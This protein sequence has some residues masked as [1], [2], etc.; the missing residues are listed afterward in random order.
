MAG[1]PSPA[2]RDQPSLRLGYDAGVFELR[3]DPITGWWSAIVTDRS[4]EHS[5]FAVE[6]L[7]V[8][9][10]HCRH[11]DEAPTEDDDRVRRVTL[12]T[13]AF[14]RI[15]P[16]KDQGAQMAISEVQASSGSW[17]ILVGPRGHH[18]SLA[19]ARPQLAV[20]LLRG[21]RD[22][23]REIGEQPLAEGEQRYVQ[24]VQSYGRA[25]LR[26]ALHT[27]RALGDHPTTYSCTPRPPASASTRPSTGTGS[28]TL[29][30]ASS[31]DWNARPRLRSTRRRPSTP[32]RSSGA[33]SIGPRA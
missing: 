7:P 11:C 24:A 20:N 30:C 31:R 2:G 17:E 3:R 15:D 33:S 29:A 1:A 26:R 28:C 13:D 16:G 9:G 6:A 18:E 8:E 23:M 5:S 21:L 10:S 12:R 14:H 32:P 4:F 27:L 19:D 25:T 22:A